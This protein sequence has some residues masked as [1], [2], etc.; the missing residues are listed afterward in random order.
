MLK[1]RL[2]TALILLPLMLLAIL[3]LPSGYFATIFAMLML[4][5]AWEWSGL[6][7]FAGLAF[8]FFYTL[9][10]FSGIVAAGVL[11]SVVH[12][13][14]LVS[15]SL[16]TQSQAAVV[17]M[18]ILSAGALM[19]LWLFIGI[20]SYQKDGVRVGFSSRVI[21]SL[22]GIIVLVSCWVAV[23]TLRL[24]SGF[25]PAWLIFVLFLVFSVDVGGYFAGRACGKTPLVSRVSPKKTWAGF[26]GGVI[27]SIIIAIVAGWFFHLTWMSYFI[28]LSVAVFVAFV[29]VVGDL[30]ISLL[31][32]I[33]GVKDTGN[34]I[35]GHGGVL[36]RLDSVAAAT[37]VFVLI[38]LLLGW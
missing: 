6:V 5:A 24:H 4:M 31:K 7:G 34:I 19:W 38:A 16:L 13:F 28:F 23:M 11:L 8:R 9:L 25:G 32:R 12:S 37:V 35:P 36:D 17:L 21:R 18:S 33:S 3:Y 20:I 27:F 29:S 14:H 26:F 10:I 2:I 22:A 1:T 15:T 30:G